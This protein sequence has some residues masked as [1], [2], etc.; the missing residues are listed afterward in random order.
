MLESVKIKQKQIFGPETKQTCLLSSLLEVDLLHSQR[1]GQTKEKHINISHK[2][3][4]YT[5]QLLE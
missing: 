3:H 1:K 2:G 5:L 4:T